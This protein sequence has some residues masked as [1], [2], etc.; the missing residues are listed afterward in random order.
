MKI[1]GD[2]SQ[3]EE[4]ETALKYLMKQSNKQYEEQNPQ[5]EWLRLQE[6]RK[7][8]LT[9]GLRSNQF[10]MFNGSFFKFLFLFANFNW[11][12][13]LRRSKHRFLPSK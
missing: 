3:N 10:N 6:L 9:N 1:S 5:E 4:W 11:F 13:L 7:Q 2:V 8:S 12:I